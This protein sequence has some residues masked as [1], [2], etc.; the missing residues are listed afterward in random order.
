[1]NIGFTDNLEIKEVGKSKFDSEFFI[2]ITITDIRS[3]EIG[4]NG[5]LITKSIIY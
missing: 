2:K 4:Y 3:K 1:M 5:N